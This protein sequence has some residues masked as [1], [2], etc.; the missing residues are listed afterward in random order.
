MKILERDLTA[1][2]VRAADEVFLSSTL[3]DLLPVVAV[4]GEPVGDGTP[5][6]MTRRLS[7]AFAAFCAR[8]VAEVYEPRY[9]E[10]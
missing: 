1:D 6:P 7:E 9:A 4:D 10:F 2:D 8:R 3:R 5:G